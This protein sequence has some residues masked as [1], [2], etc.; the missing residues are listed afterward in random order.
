M[1]TDDLTVYGQR[2]MPGL[3]N[4]YLGWS[5]RG[6]SLFTW[7]RVPLETGQLVPMGHYMKD[8]IHLGVEGNTK[9]EVA[10]NLFSLWSGEELLLEAT[11]L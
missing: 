10:Q 11:S 6:C 7:P 2:A 4:T 1:E 5:G 8:H 3:R 9:V